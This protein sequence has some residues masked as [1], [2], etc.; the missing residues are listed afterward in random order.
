MRRFYA[1]PEQIDGLSIKLSTEET[2]HLRDVLRLGAGERVQVFNG[3]GKEFIA[4]II[5]VGKRES[6]LETLEEVTPPAPESPLDLTIVASVYKN[7][8]FDLVVQKAVEL[9]VARLAPIVTFRS[10]SRI[11][12]ALNRTERWRKIALEA[13]KQCERARIMSIDDPVPFSEF[14]LRV[15]EESETL[16][17]FSEKDGRSIPDLEGP[18]KITALIGPKGGWEDSEIEIAEQR[19]FIPVKLGKRIMKAETAVITFAALLQHRFGD[20]R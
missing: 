3:E 1:P 10:E 9:G 6:V 15:S 8:K 13:T 17:M 18:K 20:L 11:D 12:A 2:R 7:D 14:I 19:G 4:E 16:L 5:S